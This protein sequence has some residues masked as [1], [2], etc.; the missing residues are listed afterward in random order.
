MLF[1]KQIVFCFFAFFSCGKR[2]FIERSEFSEA[3]DCEPP[4]KRG[5]PESK[6]EERLQVI[7]IYFQNNP[8][9]APQGHIISRIRKRV[10]HGSRMR[11]PSETLPAVR[12]SAAKETLSSKASFPRLANT[13]PQR[14]GLLCSSNCN[15]FQFCFNQ[16]FYRSRLAVNQK[17][18]AEHE[19]G[20]RGGTMCASGAAHY[21]NTHCVPQQCVDALRP[22]QKQTLQLV[23]NYLQKKKTAVRASRSHN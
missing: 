2:N 21:F 19:R 16:H 18:D 5:R 13:S 1:K 10:H 14:S 20:Y 9:F 17:K 3:R 4:A 15:H 12:A 23:S 11:A 8:P 7:L 6:T 22:K